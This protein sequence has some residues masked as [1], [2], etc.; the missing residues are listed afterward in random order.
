MGGDAVASAQARGGLPHAD[1]ALFQYTGLG[2]QLIVGFV[3]D[4]HVLFGG[5]AS[6]HQL[7][8]TGADFPFRVDARSI[9]TERADKID[10]ASDAR[11]R[12]HEA[13][14]SEIEVVHV[15]G[16]VERSLLGIDGVQ[17]RRSR[18]A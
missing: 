2:F 7:Q 12:I 10:Q 4:L 1:V 18:S 5:R 16:C 11:H 13:R 14:G 6:R 17:G 15:K 8:L 3:V 9:G